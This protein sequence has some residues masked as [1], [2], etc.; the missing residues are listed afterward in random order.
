[1]KKAIFLLPLA[2]LFVSCMP[3]VKLP[4]VE[5]KTV[6][7][8][9]QDVT[10]H[11]SFSASLRGEQDVDIV[12]QVSGTL[13]EVRVKPGQLVK[14]GQAMFVID[15]VPAQAELRMAQADVQVAKASSATAKMELE[16]KRDL[17]AKN[18][19]SDIQVKKAENEYATALAAIEQAEARVTNAKQSLSF[20]VVTAPCDGIVGDLPFRVGALVG[21][22]NPVPLT[23]VSNNKNIIAMM[24]LTE[25]DLLQFFDGNDSTSLDEAI[26]QLPKV[27]LRTSIGKIYEHEGTVT[28]VSG[29]IN[30]STGTMT[31]RAYFPNPSG[32]L[33]SGGAGEVVVPVD[34]KGALIIPQAATYALQDKIMTYKVVDNKAQGVEVKVIPTDD[35]QNYIVTSG[36]K[37]GDVVV[38]D[39]AGNIKEGEEVSFQMTM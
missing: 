33:R 5:Y 34:V 36:L 29:V 18:I 4:K 27:Q 7:V 9:A 35:N 28:N 22:S 37:A 1:M 19:I 14:A 21:P 17:R 30:Q 23:T 25:R 15:Q 2:A 13:L 12:P 3:D 32:K 8:K 16:S 38:A 31:V 10:L 20:T 24:S 26:K 6:E 11:Y 39:G